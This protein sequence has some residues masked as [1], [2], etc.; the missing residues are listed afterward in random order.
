MRTSLLGA[1]GSRKYLSETERASFLKAAHKSKHKTFILFVAYT[2][3]RVTE[4]L[5]V[6]AHHF[7]DDGPGARSVIIETLKQRKSGVFRAVPIPD[8]LFDMIV[9]QHDLLSINPKKLLWPRTR[10]WG[11]M[12]IKA[13]AT[14]AKIFSCAAC[15]KGLRHSVAT[16]AVNR[17]VPIAVIQQILGHSNPANTQIYANV[18]QETVRRHFTWI[19]NT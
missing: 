3:C 15:P 19:D 2:G 5:R 9:R 1:D 7:I 12:T 11:W 18:N 13:V 4:A 8:S 10:Q 14:E 6:R 16:S 17:D